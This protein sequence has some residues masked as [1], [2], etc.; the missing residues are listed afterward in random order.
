[1]FVRGD[2]NTPHINVTRLLDQLRNAGFYKIAFEIKSYSAA[3]LPATQTQ[4]T[5]AKPILYRPAPRWQFWA[6]LGGALFIHGV[7]VVA[8][9]KREPPP[10]DLSQ[11]PDRR[12]HRHVG[13]AP[14]DRTD[15]AAG[16]H[17]ASGTAANAG[18]PAGVPR[19]DNSSAEASAER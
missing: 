8:A 2:A 19:R 13:D 3:E 14:T 6:F 1:M 17:S 12:G 5:M 11:I 7:A 16:R 9:I 18:D 10:V 4:I 15:A